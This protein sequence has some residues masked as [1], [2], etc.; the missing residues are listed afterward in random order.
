MVRF[1]NQPFSKTAW[2][3]C[4]LVLALVLGACAVVPGGGDIRLPFVPGKLSLNSDAPAL[5]FS[6]GNLNGLWAAA[7][8]ALVMVQRGGN[9][10]AVQIVGLDNA[11]TLSGDNFLWLRAHAERGGRF[12]LQNLINDVGGVPTP[13]SSLD[14]SDLRSGTDTMGSYNW[15][16]WRSGAKTNCVIA[17]RRLDHGAR[18]MPKATRS[19]DIFLRNCVVGSI[20]DALQPILDNRIGHSVQT[21]TASTAGGVR[22][23]SPLA[24]PRQ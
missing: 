14:N 16:K 22:S 2:P 23:L 6:R 19:L 24:G 10:E 1:R 20:D 4:A 7:P 18:N 5:Q 9:G 3:K 13:F 11:T 12:E 17:F 8:E 15:K 21:T